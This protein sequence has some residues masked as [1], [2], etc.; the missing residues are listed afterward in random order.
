MSVSTCPIATVD[1]PVGRVWRLLANPSC[2]SL[3]WDAQTFSIIPEGPA[4]PGQ[5]IFAGAVALGK[6]VGFHITVRAVTPEK[7]QLELVTRLPFGI[8]VHNH[9][10]CTPLDGQHTRV[11]FG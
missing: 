5:E 2:Y 8:T 7:H 11:S 6:R 3:W 9:I 4:Q 1:A 10:T